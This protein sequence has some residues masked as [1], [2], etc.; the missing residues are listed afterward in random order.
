MPG[1]AA[2][3]AASRTSVAA[4]RQ[5][6]PASARRVPIAYLP[7]WRSTGLIAASGSRERMSGRGLSTATIAASIPPPTAIAMLC[8]LTIRCEPIGN[9]SDRKAGLECR[10]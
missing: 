9:A 3:G 5:A 7:L 1:I 2:S 8:K 4:A 6:S 10:T